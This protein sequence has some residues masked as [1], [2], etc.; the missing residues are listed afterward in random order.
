M[1]F[2]PP[3]LNENNSIL[4]ETELVSDFIQEQIT[5]QSNMADILSNYII[6][7]DIGA[8]KDTIIDKAKAVVKF[9]GNLL[10]KI[11]NAIMKV[12]SDYMNGLKLLIALIPGIG[13]YATPIQIKLKTIP[14][15]HSLLSD[16]PTS[17]FGE[18]QQYEN[19]SFEELKSYIED[20]NMKEYATKYMNEVFCKAVKPLQNIDKIEQFNIYSTT[21]SEE[22]KGASIE[23]VAK[24]KLKV[25]V[26]EHQAEELKKRVESLRKGYNQDLQKIEQMIAANCK[27]ESAEQAHKDELILNIL[28]VEYAAMF[29]A[30][31]KLARTELNV[32]QFNYNTYSKNAKKLLESIKNGETNIYNIMK[33]ERRHKK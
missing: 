3:Y 21:V 1:I 28:K 17:L 14:L 12:I 32:L 8:L 4:S 9:L 19:K 29:N 22:I 30:V 10:L 11:V 7:M 20:N 24:L 5:E 33:N 16:V 26:M 15:K 27:G 13:K 25:K 23:I 6:E 2:S 31:G 18:I